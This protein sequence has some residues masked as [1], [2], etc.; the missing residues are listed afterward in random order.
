MLRAGRGRVN[1]GEG[2]CVEAPPVAETRRVS[3]EPRNQCA[4]QARRYFARLSGKDATW[5]NVNS[6]R[7]K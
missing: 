4:A 6:T 7:K 1:P 2:P 5:A 3:S